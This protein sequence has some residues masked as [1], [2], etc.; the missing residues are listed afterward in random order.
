M[1]PNTAKNNVISPDFLAWKFCGKARFP[2][3]FG[4]FARNYAET[5]PFR[6]IFTPGNQ[7]KLRY[8]SQWK[9]MEECIQDIY[10]L[11]IS[12]SYDY[13]FSRSSRCHANEIKKIR[14]VK[15]IFSF[16]VWYHSIFVMYLTKL[17]SMVFR[18]DFI[19]LEPVFVTVDM[20][21]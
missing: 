8:F 14:A 11:V 1:I 4:R 13:D 17:P 6:K 12:I 3:S 5:L 18:C 9:C 10:K 16:M 2:H 20:K 21:I 19:C 7:V 15:L